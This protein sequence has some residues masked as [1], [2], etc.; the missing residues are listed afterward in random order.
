M[1]TLHTSIMHLENHLLLLLSLDMFILTFLPA[2]C[3]TSLLSNL[4]FH[5]YN[6]GYNFQF[7]SWRRH[8]LTS[9]YVCNFIKAHNLYF[10]E[11]VEVFFT[12]FH[13]L[14]LVVVSSLPL[15]IILISVP[16]SMVCYFTLLWIKSSLCY[17]DFYQAPDITYDNVELIWT[18]GWCSFSR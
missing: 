11:T 13:M 5:P 17:G 15:F 14:G 8:T 7:S 4:L 3:V 12:F 16:I 10:D 18:F 6:W 2:N 9:L 1:T